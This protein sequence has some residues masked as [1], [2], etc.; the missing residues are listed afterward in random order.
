MGNIEVDLEPLVE[1]SAESD[2]FAAK[3]VPVLDFVDVAIQRPWVEEDIHYF[4]LGQDA[5]PTTNH[6]AVEVVA[7]GKN[8]YDSVSNQLKVLLH[9]D[10]L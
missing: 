6:P 2:T 3:P 10:F 9:P 1:N 5:D 8:P 7:V 4:S